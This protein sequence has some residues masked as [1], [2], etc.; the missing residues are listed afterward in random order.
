MI[1]LGI[2]PGLS[3]ALVAIDDMGTDD[4]GTCSVHDMPLEARR[5]GGNQIDVTSLYQLLR[6]LRDQHRHIV[7]YVENV[8][9]M[10]KQGVSGVFAFGE[11]FGVLRACLVCTAIPIIY[12][13]PNTW[14]RALG[15]SGREKAYALTVAKE[16]IPTM[17]K[18][19]QR[20]KDV[21]RA[22]AALIAYYG[23]LF[24]TEKKK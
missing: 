18:Y 10:P 19:L 3:G 7:A 4:M 14:K 2:D 15:L 12:I 13:E 21:G 16:R 17:A 24:Y 8:H 1:Y 11:G 6:V 20:K 5:K 22:D 9:A 23:A